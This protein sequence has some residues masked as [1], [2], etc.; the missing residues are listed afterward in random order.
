[1]LGGKYNRHYMLQSRIIV[2]LSRPLIQYEKHIS[3]LASHIPFKETSCCVNNSQLHMHSWTVSC[4]PDRRGFWNL[5][6]P[7]GQ[8]VLLPSARQ[9]K[10]NVPLSVYPFVPRHCSAIKASALWFCIIEECG[11]VLQNY[12]FQHIDDNGHLC[13]LPAKSTS[14]VR[15]LLIHFLDLFCHCEQLK[16]YSEAFKFSVHHKCKF[17]DSAFHCRTIHRNIVCFIMAKSFEQLIYC[18]NMFCTM[19]SHSFLNITPI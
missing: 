5:L 10:W 3:V 17:T 13:Y 15:P 1:V 14:A 4:H 19:N 18:S 6:T 8:N 2:V 12:P 16:P 11:F 9:H 7:K